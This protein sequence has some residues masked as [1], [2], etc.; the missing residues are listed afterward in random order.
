LTEYSAVIPFS[1][2]DFWFRLRMTDCIMVWS[3][4]AVTLF[5]EN[6]IN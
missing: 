6:G 4:P 1:I 5:Y 3:L 2:F